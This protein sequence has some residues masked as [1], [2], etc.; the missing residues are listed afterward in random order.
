MSYA[1]V[2]IGGTK[3][4]AGIVDANGNILYQTRVPMVT[5]EQA[6][7]GFSCVER[8]LQDVLGSPA[9]T[10]AEGIGIVAP[11]PLDPRTGVILN[12]P[13]VP[14]W[15][16]FPLGD[17]VRERF[18][19]PVQIENDANAAA[20]AEALWGAGKGF[21]NVFY[22]TMGTG[23]GTGL[24]L[25]GQIYNGRTG[26][27][28]EGG[29]LPIDMHGARCGCGKRGCIEALASG[30][31][32]ANR[33]RAKI[34]ESSARTWMI[35]LGGG[36]TKGITAEAVA[37]AWREG[38]GLATETLRET[39]TLVTI[40]LGAII[41]LLEP[42][43]IVFGGGIGELTSEWFPEIQKLLPEW[44]MNKRCTEIPLLLARYKS[45]AGIAG[46]A[47]LCVASKASVTHTG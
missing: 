47:A 10:N 2:D 28:V 9:G 39:M 41:D 5:C 46:A 15:R 43:V 23:I 42:D 24:V 11:G 7:D 18:R 3:V 17:Q 40:W 6:S 12:P 35:D 19:L 25:D 14:C 38:D 20:L 16:N 31:A 22:V 33:A 4:A 26:A 34:S 44:T 32:I 1:A 21:R 8:A 45:D 27:A 13:N 29:H 30:P 36:D 37:T